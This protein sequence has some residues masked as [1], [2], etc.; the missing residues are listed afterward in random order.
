[1]GRDVVQLYLCYC[2]HNPV[3]A[4]FCADFW[5]LAASRLITMREDHDARNHLTSQTAVMSLV[6]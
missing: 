1:M 2:E 4:D 3:V 5:A 6:V